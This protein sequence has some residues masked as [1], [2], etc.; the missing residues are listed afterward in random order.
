MYPY[1]SCHYYGKNSEWQ[2]A[3]E[4][5]QNGGDKQTISS[6]HTIL[7]LYLKGIWYLQHVM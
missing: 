3:E 2:T 5:T 4:G 7:N 1:L 6:L